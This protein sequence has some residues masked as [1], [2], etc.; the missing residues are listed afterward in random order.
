MAR[1]VIGIDLGTTNCAVAYCD[2]EADD[3]AITLLEIDQVVAPGEVGTKTS[4]PSFLLMPSEHEMAT[5][6]MAL[7]W[8]DG[9]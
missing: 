1:F 5:G 6:S 4:L 3:G 2:S 8:N 7:P 9:P